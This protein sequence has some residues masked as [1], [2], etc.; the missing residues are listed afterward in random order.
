MSLVW[1]IGLGLITLYVSLLWYDRFKD[2][3]LLFS[4]GYYTRFSI[5]LTPFS[6]NADYC[7]DCLYKLACYLFILLYE[8]FILNAFGL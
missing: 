4:F 8:S 2:S 6:N 7:V 5:F 3:Y 1:V